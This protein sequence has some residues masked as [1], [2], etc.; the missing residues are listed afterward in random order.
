MNFLRW[1]LKL[2]TNSNQKENIIES[3]LPSMVPELPFGEEK[4][5]FAFLKWLET[6]MIYTMYVILFIFA[7]LLLLLLIKKTRVWLIKVI[8]SCIQLFK[9]LGNRPVDDANTRAYVDE[10][11]NIFR[12]KDWNKERQEQV[13][14][15]IGKV[16]R[17]EP[18]WKSLSNEEKVRYTYRQYLLQQSVDISPSYTVREIL[19]ELKSSELVDPKRVDILRKAYEQ[20]RYGDQNIT[21]EQVEEIYQL[22]NGRKSQ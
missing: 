19:A 20:T 5:P 6:I 13:K 8:A 21:D 10:R 2:L 16:I 4:E 22:L 1:A 18:S 12:W 14:A 17:R 3:D 15:F 7:L 11:E 9:R